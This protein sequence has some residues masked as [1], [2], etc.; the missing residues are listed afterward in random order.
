MMQG[1]PV[2]ILLVE[3][4]EVVRLATQGMLEHLGYRVLAAADGAEALAVSERWTDEIH[5]LV[6]DVVMPGM[7]GRELADKLRLTRPSIKV[8]YTSGYT[9]DVIVHHGILDADVEFISKPFD[10]DALA[11]RVRTILDGSPG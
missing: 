3:D 8:L 7:N 5:L 4:E 11:A 6:T 9:D 1:S 10:R 2:V